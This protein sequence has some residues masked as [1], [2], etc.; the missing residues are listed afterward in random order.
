MTVGW[1]Q[2]DP[3]NTDTAEFGFRIVPEPA[4]I[5]LLLAGCLVTGMRRRR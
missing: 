1:S 3:V 5:A 4:T 2:S